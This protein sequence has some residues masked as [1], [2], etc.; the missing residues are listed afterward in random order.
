MC[1]A[2]WVL[3]VDDRA[4]LRTLLELVLT[5]AGYTVHS[6]VHGGH[7]L[8]LLGPARPC[9]ILLDLDMPVMDDAAFACAYRQRDDADA[10]IVVMTAG[11]RRTDVAALAARTPPEAQAAPGVRAARSARVGRRSLRGGDVSRRGVTR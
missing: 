6:A 8:A 2:R 1:R 3:V 5:D 4:V 10:H 11:A 9:L 7:A